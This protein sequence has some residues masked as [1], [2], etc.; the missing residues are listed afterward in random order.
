MAIRKPPKSYEEEHEREFDEASKESDDLLL[1][2][3]LAMGMCGIGDVENTLTETEQSSMMDELIAREPSPYV[4]EA[5]TPPNEKQIAEYEQKMEETKH[6]GRV[7]DPKNAEN[8][9]FNHQSIIA[10]KIGM[11]G[12]V[13]AEKQGQLDAYYDEIVLIP[14]VTS[15]D[16]S[17]CGDCEDNKANGP[18]KPSEFPEPPHYGCRCG[19]G[20]PILLMPGMDRELL[21]PGEGEMGT[22]TTDDKFKEIITEPGET[23]LTDYVNQ[24]GW[25]DQL[26]GLTQEQMEEVYSYKRNGYEAINQYGRTGELPSGSL[27]NKEEFDMVLS[28]MNAAI[29]ES[30]IPED[31]ILFRGVEDGL[32]AVS[33]GA[34]V[35]D[36]AFLSTSADFSV[37]AEFALENEANTIMEL[38]IPAGEKGLPVSQAMSLF[39]M[40]MS[41]AGEQEILLPNNYNLETVGFGTR[42]DIWG[43]EY[44]TVVCKP[45]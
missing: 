23:T 43:V 24:T 12:S 36:G 8:T 15:E 2:G 13:E 17:V 5:P 44:R 37:A 39:D 20:E 9:A 26:S 28:T 16:D 41:F 11:F 27:L 18:Y 29:E 45:F 19:P 32:N 38:H 21:P 22:A 40:P 14:W 10:D 33:I 42:T 4:S 3:G 1:Y 31:V 7:S 30:V 35:T 34:D 25:I 6:Y